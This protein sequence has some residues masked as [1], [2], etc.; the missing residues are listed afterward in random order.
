MIPKKG[1]LDPSTSPPFPVAAADAL[2]DGQLRRNLVHATSVIQDK[3][4]GVVAE[5][6]DWED[7]RE[8]GRQI[9]QHSVKFLDAYLQQFEENFVAAWRNGPLG[10]RCQGSQRNRPPTCAT[11]LRASAC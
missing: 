1:P 9:R 7:L 5:M 2:K 10:A 8:S 4:S 11:S 6:S 3:R